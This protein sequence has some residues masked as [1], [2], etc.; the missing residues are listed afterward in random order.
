MDLRLV[1]AVVGRPSWGRAALSAGLEWR[2]VWPA[3]RPVRVPLFARGDGSTF[4]L[5]MLGLLY[6]A[7]FG[8]VF[9]L[10]SYAFTGGK[11]DF[12]HAV[13]SPQSGTTY[14]VTLGCS[15]R[16]AASWASSAFDTPQPPETPEAHQWI[17]GCS[18]RSRHLVVIMGSTG[19]RADLLA[20][21]HWRGPPRRAGW[22]CRRPSPR[23]GDRG[24]AL[25]GQAILDYLHVSWV[26]AR[27]PAV[28]SPAA[29]GT[30]T[31]DGQERPDRRD[32]G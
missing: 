9:G 18:D 6:G 4:P 14:T 24:F 17:G 16:P 1:E 28:A 25:F 30:R 31:A 19:D 32:P 7:A 20:L 27:R 5:I 26:P 11:R 12:R 10:I 15:A 29:R 23:S 22:R 8:I 13:R 21:T 3:A 2:L